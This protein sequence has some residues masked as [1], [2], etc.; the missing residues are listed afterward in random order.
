VKK[1]II[2]ILV[3]TIILLFFTNCKKDP[4]RSEYIY[5]PDGLFFNAQ[6]GN[7]SFYINDDLPNVIELS[8]TLDHTWRPDS[9]LISYKCCYPLDE[10]KDFKIIFQVQ[11]SKDNFTETNG[12]YIYNNFFEML[13]EGQQDYQFDDRPLPKNGFY[14]KYYV[15][16]TMLYVVDDSNP[17]LPPAFDFNIN[18]II[19]KDY[20]DHK[21]YHW[22]E[23]IFSGDLSCDL[24]Y[25]YSN[26]GNLVIDT[27]IINNA[28]LKGK[29]VQGYYP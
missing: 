25:C 22:N 20:I 27:L 4:P 17:L 10:N 5:E 15:N 9:M 2:I 6:I 29:F 28:T 23:I 8:S 26:N 24:C 19:I 12:N 13:F 11:E 1:A 16:D 21:N 18:E 7:E 3:F 14:I